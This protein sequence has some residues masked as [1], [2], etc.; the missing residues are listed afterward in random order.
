MISMLLNRFFSILSVSELTEENLL[1]RGLSKYLIRIEI[2]PDHPV[3][4]GH[5]PGS[6]VIPG[7][8]QIQI[9]TEMLDEIYNKKF[10]LTSADNIK[11]L[12]LINPL[13]TGSYSIELNCRSGSA[14]EVTVN[15]VAFN[16]QTIFLKLKANYLSKS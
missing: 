1:N 15:A 4:K 3:F 5:F 8:C 2:N 6:P 7:V 12:S 10:T 16:D 9:I 13:V 11:F 14:D